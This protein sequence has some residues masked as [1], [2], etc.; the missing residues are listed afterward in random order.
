LIDRGEPDLQLCARATRLSSRDLCHSAA[1]TTDHEPTSMV[2]A[3]A[4]QPQRVQ[5]SHPENCPARDRLSEAVLRS[6][7]VV[8]AL[9]TGQL[10]QPKVTLHA[11]RE[12]WIAAKRSY[13]EHLREHGC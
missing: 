5:E 7:K 2:P 8:V 4:P 11:A 3:M 6:L 10:P 1:L 12:N 9:K 13:F